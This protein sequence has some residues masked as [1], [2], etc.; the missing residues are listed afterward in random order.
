M[1]SANTFDEGYAEGVRATRIEAIAVAGWQALIA[2]DPPDITCRIPPWKGLN[3][4]DTARMLR[5]ARRIVDGE[6]PVECYA[7]AYPEVAR[8][9]REMAEATSSCA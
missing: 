9:M 7:G 2:L 8:A 6:V 4:F 3:G 5:D 1:T